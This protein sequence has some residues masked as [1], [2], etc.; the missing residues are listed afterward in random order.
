MKKESEVLCIGEMLWDNMPNGSIPGGEP[1]NVAIN[2]SNLV[3]CAYLISRV[4]ADNAGELLLDFLKEKKLSKD[5]VQTDQDLPT[6]QVLVHLDQD[7]EPH[8]EIC[9][10]V[11]W[12]SIMANEHS[13]NIPNQAD[14]VVVGSLAS[15]SMLS[16]QSILKFLQSGK[17]RIMDVNL[18]P[19]YCNREIIEPMLK[20]IDIVK[21][22]ADK[23]RQILSWDSIPEVMGI[24]SMILLFEIRY[25]IHTIC[26]TKGK[27]GAV[28]YENGR[29]IQHPGF[30]IEE[31][32]PAGAGDAFLSG[33]IFGILHRYNPEEKI[34]FA[35][36]AG[37]YVAS[38]KG[39]TPEFS[40]SDILAIMN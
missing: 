22:S 36:A 39:A 26:I 14:L 10:P 2:L 27:D 38:Q 20:Y 15:K 23:L 37:A 3:V 35:C 12:N 25:D 18:K 19:P 29:F 5:Y 7:N 24:K 9:H 13:L 6:R 16:Q 4:G 21:M 40:Y 30:N 17:T 8:Y 33:F 32:E 1:M 31:I 34:T 11:V 28:L